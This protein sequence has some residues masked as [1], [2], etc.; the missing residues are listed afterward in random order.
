MMGCEHCIC[1]YVNMFTHKFSHSPN[2]NQIFF[3]H[4]DRCANTQEACFLTSVFSFV[5]DSSY[6]DLVEGFASRNKTILCQTCYDSLN[7][8]YVKHARWKRLCL[9]L[10][11]L[12]THF[13]MHKLLHVHNWLK[14]MF[15]WHNA[16]ILICWA[17]CS[18]NIVGRYNFRG[19]R[20]QMA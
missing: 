12:K 6:I 7:S 3:F 11:D 16:L 1:I 20:R 9:S 5:L 14:M 10:S 8:F 2:C 17:Q 13:Y 4:A 19:W 18:K 15:R